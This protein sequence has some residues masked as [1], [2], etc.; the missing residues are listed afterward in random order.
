[1][2]ELNDKPLEA[3]D[4][5]D[6]RRALHGAGVEDDRWEAKGGE[7]GSTPAV[8]TSMHHRWYVRVSCWG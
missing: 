1:M 8:R 3:V 4:V 7:L 2:Q 5:D 6:L